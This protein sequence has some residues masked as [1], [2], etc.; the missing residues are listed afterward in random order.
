MQGWQTPYLGLRDLPREFSESKLQAF[1]N[2]S[3][4]E[5]ELFARRR[6]DNLK[7]GLALLLR[8]TNSASR[9]HESR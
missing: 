4:A 5:H 7:L 6:G 9:V 2:F 8:S 3:H 1:F